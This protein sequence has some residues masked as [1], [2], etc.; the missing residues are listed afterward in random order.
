MNKRWILALA[1]TGF[2]VA[3]IMSITLLVLW[4]VYI[5]GDFRTIS[6]LSRS[7]GNTQQVLQEHGDPTMRWVV[8]A[9]GSAF[10]AVILTALS[11]FFA[12]FLVDRRYQRIQTDWLAMTTHEL[13]L[14]T[15]NI[16]LFAQTLQKPGIQESDRARFVG[17]ILQEAQRL[18]GLVS[19]I[20]LARRIEGGMQEIRMENV[21]AM[22]WLASARKRPASP[23]FQLE[24][25]REAR[26][27]VDKRQLE[28]ILD[29]LVHNAHKYGDGSEPRVVVLAAD[30]KV[31][32]EVRDKGIGVPPAL[33]KKVF[34][35]FYRVQQREHRRRT[36]TGLGLYIAKS[37]V[38]L[39]GGTMGVRDNPEGRG[40]A[41]W[42][43]FKEVV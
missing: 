7:M 3:V 16:H 17:L 12:A 10:F 34:R 14:P 20:L 32:I 15:A 5:I 25:V 21:A 8:L 1:I 36:G 22:A 26:I 41:F 9:M 43:S 13:K 31:T 6:H 11:L 29:N 40:S 35:R 42:M 24:G 28:T 4:N 38:G 37:L 27:R 30:G 18:D 39:M 23:T 2:V 19:R 33:R